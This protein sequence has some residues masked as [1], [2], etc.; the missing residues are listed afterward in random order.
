MSRPD[1]G[2]AADA[3]SE[4]VA[5]V[6]GDQLDLATPCDDTTLGVLLDHVDGLAMAFTVAARKAPLPPG[7]DPTPT[8]DAAALAPDWQSRIPA[9]L[10]ELAEAWR[11]SAAWEG[12]TS[13][14][15]IDLPADA[16]GATGLDE[17]V[18]HGWDVARSLGRSYRIDDASVAGARRFVDG[19]T[20]PGSQPPP[21]LFGPPVP[22]PDDASPLDRLLGLTG[23]DPR[24]PESVSS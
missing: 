15:G 1:L 9:R 7:V 23:R 11:Q 4:L 12:T 18:V 21:G 16:C 14:G 20:A 22:V 13:V 19:V 6:S 17:L 10:M 24:W 3:L 8:A 5:G 2:P